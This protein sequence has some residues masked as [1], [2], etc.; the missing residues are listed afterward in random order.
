MNVQFAS[1]RRSVD[2]LLKA[3]QV[4]LP[5]A[6]HFHGFEQFC[7]PLGLAMMPS[8][9]SSLLEF[10]KETVLLVTFQPRPSLAGF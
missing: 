6:E 2:L 3:Q 10:S 4:D 8:A 5:L 1:G 7:Q 9:F